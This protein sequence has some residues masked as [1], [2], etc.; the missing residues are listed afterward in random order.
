VTGQRDAAAE[1]AR[2][3]DPRV[4]PLPGGS[5]PLTLRT[6]AGDF[7]LADYR[8]RLGEREWSVLHTEALITIGDEEDFLRDRRDL[9]PYGVALWPSAIALAH[10]LHERRDALRGARVLELGAGTGLPGIVAAGCG[11]AVVQT[12]RQ[13]VALEVCRRNAARNGIAAIEHRQVD[14]SEWDDDARYD[15]IIG[16]DVLYAAAMHGHLLGIIERNLA[17][18]GTVLFGDPFRAPALQLLQDL[19]DDGWTVRIA[20]WNVGEEPALRAFGVIDLTPPARGRRPGAS[21]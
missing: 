19:E 15:W 20:K 6:T 16:S 17:P 2:V 13:P 8:I 1:A 7:R 12:D 10:E 21:R 11:A 5:D 4:D 9:L 18:G 3:A 14:W